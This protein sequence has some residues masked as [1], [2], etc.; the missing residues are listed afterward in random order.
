MGVADD[1]Y[2]LPPG[3]FTRAR[4]ERAKAL[5]KE[6]KREE[7]DAVKALRKPTVA[8]WALNQ[9]ARR[10]AKGVER[11]LA[12]GEELR[13]AQ[14]ELLA[15]GDRK[16]FQSA[17]AKER[18]EVAGL[19]GEA[20]ELAAEAGERPTPALREKI[21]ETLHAAALDEETGEELR[22]GRLVRERAAIG[23]FGGMTAAAPP[24]RGR[25]G[26][27][28]KEGKAGSAAG[29]EARERRAPEGGKAAGSDGKRGKA[30]GSDGTRRKAGASGGKRGKASDDGAKRRAEAERRATAERRAE[31]ERRQRLAGARTDERHAQARARSGREGDRA[32]GDARGGRE[33]SRRGGERPGEDHRGA[34]EGGP[35]RADGREEGPC[36]RR[37]G[38]G[39]G[40]ARVLG[41]IRLHIAQR[42][43]PWVEHEAADLVAGG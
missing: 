10:R 35:P 12:A 22:A 36:P 21:S 43:G 17:A 42:S 27:A 37:A 31:A 24:T 38:P 6:G 30:A 25:G 14:E 13:A 20:A 29:G 40:R 32:R 11:L 9:L 41:G 4:D 23:G 3:E 33:G 18:D 19:A 15:G 34:P 7:A 39:R 28:L 26:T 1:L 16:A 5:R 8:A 2:A